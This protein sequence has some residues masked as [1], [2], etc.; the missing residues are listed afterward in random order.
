MVEGPEWRTH[1]RGPIPPASVITVML[2]ELL[3]FAGGAVSLIGLGLVM[4]F[5]PTLI[6]VALRILTHARRPDRLIAGM[7][8]GLAIGATVLLLV[9]QFIDP[10]TLEAALRDEVEGV[11]VRRS[12]DLAFGTLFVLAAVV[13]GVR[14]RRP[15]RQGRARL[16]RS[17][18]MQRPW[19]MIVVGAS[20]TVIGVSGLATVYV[21]ARLIRAISTD[22]PIRVL[23][24]AVF[25][26]ATVSPYVLLTWAWRRLPRVAHRITTVFHRWA[27]MDRRPWEFGIVLVIGLILLGLGVWGSPSPA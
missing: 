12:V 27:T 25:L 5:S 7:L 17:A 22:D 2:A 8:V 3:R 6:A 18:G 19:Q 10:R 23:A 13:M 4:G 11:L 15:R 1:W 14:L 16:P 21:A 9:L 20:N 26:V 24:Y